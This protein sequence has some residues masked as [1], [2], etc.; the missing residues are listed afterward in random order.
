MEQCT[1]DSGHVFSKKKKTK[2][3]QAYPFVPERFHGIHSFPNVSMGFQVPE[4]IVSKCFQTFPKCAC[5][6]AIWRFTGKILCDRFDLSTSLLWAPLRMYLLGTVKG[7]NGPRAI[8]KFV[9][10]VP[11]LFCIFA[12]FACFFGKERVI[13]QSSHCLVAW[14]GTRAQNTCL[15]WYTFQKSVVGKVFAPWRGHFSG[16]AIGRG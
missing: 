4:T 7:H 16:G 5:S 9:K 8:S 3:F 12:F 2:R 6:V 14:G 11:I 10:W 13:V 1:T 15:N